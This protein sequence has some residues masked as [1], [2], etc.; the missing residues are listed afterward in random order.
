MVDF[1]DSG[2]REERWL[3]FVA[4]ALA[5]L[6]YE[7]SIDACATCGKRPTEGQPA[8]FDPARG[9]IVC[10]ACGGGAWKLGAGTRRRLRTAL[11]GG[12]DGTAWAEVER[13]EARRAV[14][15]LA[16][17]QLGRPLAVPSILAAI[18]RTT[19]GERR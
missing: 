8:L 11:A 4:R 14:S 13:N 5:L 7:P 3:A 1:D 16:E 6:G 18:D 17:H 12:D 2:V 9:G 15:A 19:R 10:R